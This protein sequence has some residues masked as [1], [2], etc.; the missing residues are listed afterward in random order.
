MFSLVVLWDHSNNEHVKPTSAIRKSKTPTEYHWQGVICWLLSENSYGVTA[1]SC[2]AWGI[3]LPRRGFRL[4]AYHV[5][6]QIYSP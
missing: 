1:E 3:A 5:V 2:N 4:I 6:V